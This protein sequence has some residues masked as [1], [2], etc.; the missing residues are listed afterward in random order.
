MISEWKD[1]RLQLLHV[2]T[3]IAGSLKSRE[4]RPWA[5]QSSFET[6]LSDGGTV[7][8]SEIQLNKSQLEVVG[9]CF[10]KLGVTCSLIEPSLLVFDAFFSTFS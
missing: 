4:F 6:M 8:V 10:V 3:A 5:L 7:Q 2:T 1:T 9:W